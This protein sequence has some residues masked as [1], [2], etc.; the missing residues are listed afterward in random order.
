MSIRMA[1]KEAEGAVN[2]VNMV[3]TSDWF[4]NYC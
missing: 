3:V 1:K 2:V 4:T